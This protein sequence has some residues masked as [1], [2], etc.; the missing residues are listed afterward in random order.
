MN[1]YD[2]Y[3]KTYQTLLRQG[4]SGWGGEKRL[5]R[6]QE[7]IERFFQTSLPISPSRL[8]ELGCGEGN[9][10]REF[11]K[12]G[13]SVTGVDISRTAIAWA[14]EK[15]EDYDIHFQQMNLCKPDLVFPE[16]F[17]YIVDGNC[18][19]CILE[20]DR[21]EF[22]KNVYNA[23]MNDGVFFVSS[24]ISKND[25]NKVE[26]KNDLPYRFIPSSD[27][28]A[29]EL[30]NAGFEIKE[31]QLFSRLSHD[32]MVIHAAKNSCQGLNQLALAIG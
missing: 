10:T 27:F 12:L 19:H 2:I 20:E 23:L 28:L 11:S 21:C 3:E 8:L 30:M 6:N 31:R 13:F 17:Q 1:N 14:R 9:Y 25:Q 26:Y 18:L 7:L 5:S 22:L 15:S 16:P 29:N 24:L 32:H 4:Q